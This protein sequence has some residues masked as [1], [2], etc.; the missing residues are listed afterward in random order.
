MVVLLAFFWTVFDISEFLFVGASGIIAGGSVIVFG[1]MSDGNNFAAFL[2]E[3]FYAGLAVF[4]LGLAAWYLELPKREVALGTFILGCAY[5]VM[6]AMESLIEIEF[7]AV[8]ISLAIL[9][10]LFTAS[11]AMLSDRYLLDQFR[12]SGIN[13]L[14]VTFA[15]ALVLQSVVVVFYFP[16]DGKELV[17]FG[18][19]ERVLGT[20]IPKKSVDIF[21]AS[22]RNIRI[23]ALVLTILAAILLYIFIWFSKTGMALRAVSQDEEA[24][25]LAGI[26]IR[27]TTAIV[28]GIGMG[29]VAFAAVFTSSFAATPWWAPQMGWWV[30]IMAI[31]VV[32]LGGEGSL[33]GSVIGAFIIGYTEILIASAPGTTVLL[34]AIVYIQSLSVAVPLVIVIIVMIFK[35]EGL[36]GEKPEL[37]A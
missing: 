33:P 1:G 31:A 30:L 11:L 6:F 14:I 19:G 32:T 3:G 7:P 37:E 2:V 10:I 35:P 13:T 12:A 20:I 28:S 34:G 22:I 17:V 9:S 24:A 16:Q 21:G 36:F 29:L 15:L 4:T 26:D 8:F 23:I 18:A 5:P 27:K 25:A